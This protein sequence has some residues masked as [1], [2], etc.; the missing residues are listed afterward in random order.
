VTGSRAVP[1]LT[2]LGTLLL[3]AAAA[4]DLGNAEPRAELA[5]GAAGGIVFLLAAM[6]GG[7][8][9]ATAL[10]ARS[11]LFAGAGLCALLAVA[12]HGQAGEHVTRD[13]PLLLIPVF[14]LLAAA[15]LARES[16]H[17]RRR[18]RRR[19]LRSRLAGE[20]AE[21]RRWAQELHDDTL[22]ELA[23]VQVL[24]SAAGTSTDPAARARA[25]DQARDCVGRQIA[26][27]RRLIG[28]LRPLALDTAGLVPAVEEL[29]R[30]GAR[31]GLDIEVHAEPLPRLAAEAETAAYRIVQEAVTNAVRHAG[32]SR[33]SVEACA[34]PHA[35]L[36]TVRDDGR[37]CPEGLPPGFGTLGMRERAEAIGATLTVSVY[38]GV[39]VSLSIPLP[40]A[41]PRPAPRRIADPQEQ[42][43]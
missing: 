39:E 12:A 16:A 15:V 3:G 43:A 19:E 30:R 35:V 11:R 10:A 38:D 32:A 18:T 37:G 24:L 31:P 36:V 41:P 6:L 9:G 27:L 5:V 28:H 25:I 40:T 14:L 29:A 8:G 26:A 20:E 17:L 33:I 13:V 42:P 2:T 7:G 21:R 1:A 22:Q 23:A 34:L 4:I